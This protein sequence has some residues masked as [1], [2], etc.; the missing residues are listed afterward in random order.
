MNE[1]DDL[2]KYD[3]KNNKGYGTKKHIDGIKQYDT[4]YHRKTY[5]ICKNYS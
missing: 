2:S 3:I 5:G 1:N 4:E